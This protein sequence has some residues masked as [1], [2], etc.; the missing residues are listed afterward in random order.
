[1]EKLFKKSIE[2]SRA[3]FPA[4]FEKE[5]RRCFHYS[6]LFNKTKLLVIAENKD[7]THPRNRFNLKE[8]DISLKGVCSEM[9]LFLKAKSKFN[10][11]NWKKLTLI[12][13]RLNRN[14]E[15]SNSCPCNSCKSLINYLGLRNVYHSNE[16]GGFTEYFI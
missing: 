14:G 4:D 2:L 15:V 7:S 8:F 3:L 6:F 10:N 16:S 5:D 1:M 9:S 12:N 13:V 11:L